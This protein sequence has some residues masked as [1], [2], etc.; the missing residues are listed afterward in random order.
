MKKFIILLAIVVPGFVMAQMSEN[1]LWENA[2]YQVVQNGESILYTDVDTKNAAFSEEMLDQLKE[3]MFRKEG[4]VKVE[5]RNSNKT[6]RVYHF[7]Y[8]ELE[9]VKGFVLAE[10]RD[11][12]VL[13]QVEYSMH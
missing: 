10:R 9:T 5:L 3:N 8:I 4:I 6:I 1:Q 7:E 12:E 13:N 11:I 2:R